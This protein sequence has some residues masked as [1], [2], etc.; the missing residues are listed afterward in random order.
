MFN[1]GWTAAL[2]HPTPHGFSLWLI[3]LQ[4]TKYLI[5]RYIPI[6][7][8]GYSWAFGSV[9]LG[10]W[11]S[12]SDWTPS[13]FLPQKWRFASAFYMYIDLNSMYLWVTNVTDLKL[14]QFP[15]HKLLSKLLSLDPNNSSSLFNTFQN[16]S[17]LS[18]LRKKYLFCE[19]EYHASKHRKHQRNTSYAVAFFI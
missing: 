15:H 16:I 9:N 4:Y 11:D 8:Q 13:S 14:K 2:C 1:S 3:D 17:D 18:I 12:V 5:L 7:G 6:M 19:A 10:S